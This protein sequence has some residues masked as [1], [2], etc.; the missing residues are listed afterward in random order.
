MLGANGPMLRTFLRQSL[1]YLIIYAIMFGYVQW[2]EQ[3]RGMSESAAGAM[4]L[5]MSVTAIV[6]AALGARMPGLQG[7]LLVTGGALAVGA[8]LLLFTAAAN[9]LIVL[10]GIGVIFGLAQGLTGITNQSALQAQ[11]PAQHLGTSSGLFRSAQYVGAIAASTLIALSFG[12]H[13]STDGLHRLAWLLVG[14]SVL[15]VVITATDRAL[16]NNSGQ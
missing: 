15:L 5:P 16:R 9:P 1:A 14:T 2:L 3:T 13:A 8:S 11:S 4:L 6:A 10:L 12:A 7:K